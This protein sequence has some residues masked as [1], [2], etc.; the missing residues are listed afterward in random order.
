MPD[1]WAGV[2]VLIA[3]QVVIFFFTKR[4]LDRLDAAISRLEATLAETKVEMSAQITA[5]KEDLMGQMAT[6]K[7][8]LLEE[9]T[10]MND[11]PLPCCCACCNT[12]PRCTAATK[13]ERTR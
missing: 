3:V 12:N 8:G 10:A 11:E 2:A 13:D 5:F 6:N 7:A 1:N 4:S 9:L